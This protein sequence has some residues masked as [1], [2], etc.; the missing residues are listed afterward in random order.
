MAT[1]ENSFAGAPKVKPGYRPLDI[2]LKK[3]QFHSLEDI[4]NK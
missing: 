4:R 3:E 2:Y 1:L